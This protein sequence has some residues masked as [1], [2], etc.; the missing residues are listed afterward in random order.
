MHNDHYAIQTC[1]YVTFSFH[2]AG[3]TEHMLDSCNVTIIMAVVLI[4]L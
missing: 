1:A 4:V 2:A 3:K